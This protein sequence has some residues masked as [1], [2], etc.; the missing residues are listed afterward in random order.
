MRAGFYHSSTIMTSQIEL[1]P[2][3]WD[4]VVTVGLWLIGVLGFLALVTYRRTEPG[5]TF[6]VTFQVHPYFQV[7]EEAGNESTKKWEQPTPPGQSDVTLHVRVTANKPVSLSSCS[8][9]LV[10]RQLRPGIFRLWRWIPPSPKVAFVT[11][12]WDAEWER[13]SATN[14]LQHY[15]PSPVARLNSDGVGYTVTYSEPLRL[16]AGESL[17][18]RV[19]VTVF[20]D[21]EGYLEFSGPAPDGRQ[22]S[23][24]RRVKLT[25][26][27]PSSP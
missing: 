17:W 24:Y 21:W 7:P 16:L 20:R 14:P 13:Q 25:P 23:A 26:S 5:R 27:M 11:N 6:G 15:R 8:C 9:R 2:A 10:G 19:I 1:D 4:S 22:A 3:T 18:F 12:I